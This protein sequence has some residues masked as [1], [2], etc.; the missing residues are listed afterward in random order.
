ML[1][2]G[3][4]GAGTW[5]RSHS[6]EM[7]L[8]DP[9]MEGKAEAGLQGWGQEGPCPG[10]I[11]GEEAPGPGHWHRESPFNSEV[12]LTEDD[13]VVLVTR[14]GPTIASLGHHTLRGHLEPS[15]SYLGKAS[16]CGGSQRCNKMC[17][18]CRL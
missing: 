13:Q 12:A 3:D 11:C 1:F 17:V 8:G 7:D 14:R 6:R 2:M 15:R 10:H 16:T 4:L 18:S 9:N 5:Q